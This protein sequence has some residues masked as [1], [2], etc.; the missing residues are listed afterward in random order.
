VCTLGSERSSAC[1]HRLL[2]ACGVCMS[3]PLVWHLCSV[4][5][6]CRSFFSRGEFGIVKV[7]GLLKLKDA[8][9]VSF[10]SDN[11][12]LPVL[13][14]LFL[15]LVPSVRP[16]FLAGSQFVGPGLGPDYSVNRPPIRL[17]AWLC[18][19]W[20]WGRTPLSLFPV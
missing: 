15:T 17:F 5:S 19:L 8:W 9:G 4:A 14:S 20:F 13:I 3:L 16:H 2:D 1:S 10:S 7:F 11:V 6:C 12:C 18:V